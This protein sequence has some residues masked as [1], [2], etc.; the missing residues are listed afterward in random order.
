MDPL[1]ALRHLEVAA[2]RIRSGPQ[3]SSSEVQALRA[4]SNRVER[5][6]LVYLW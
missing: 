6:R 1:K 5:W 4:L 3:V 2:E